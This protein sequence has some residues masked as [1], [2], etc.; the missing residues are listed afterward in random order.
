[1]K[2]GTKST[3]PC[4]ATVNKVDIIQAENSMCTNN[5]LIMKHRAL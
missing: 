1:M 3:L 4:G 5:E 2:I